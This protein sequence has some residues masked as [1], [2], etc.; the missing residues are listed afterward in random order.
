MFNLFKKQ[1]ELKIGDKLVDKEWGDSI[2]EIVQINSSKTQVRYK[3]LKLNGN[4][5]KDGMIHSNSV[6]FIND[7]Y[8][9]INN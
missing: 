4:Q 9:K 3:Y 7:Y 6:S 5:I 1:S 2:I 8:T